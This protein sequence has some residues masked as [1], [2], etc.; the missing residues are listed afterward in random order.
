MKLNKDSRTDNWSGRRDPGS[1]PRNYNFP[2]SAREAGFY[3]TQQSNQE[4]EP[5]GWIV[6]L[7]I[8]WIVLGIVILENLN[9]V[10]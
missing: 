10:A 5:S 7:I 6:A 8:A 3:Y 2:R 9:W 4:K 1:D